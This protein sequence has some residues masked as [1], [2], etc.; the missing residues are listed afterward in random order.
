MRIIASIGDSN[1]SVKKVKY[2]KHPDLIIKFYSIRLEYF[3]LCY[4]KMLWDVF[5]RNEWAISQQR[6]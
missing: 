3:R 4:R 5:R 1:S 2:K 6:I